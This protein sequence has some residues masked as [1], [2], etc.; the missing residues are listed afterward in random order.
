MRLYL[1]LILV[2]LN[3]FSNGQKRNNKNN[4]GKVQLTSNEVVTGHLVYSEFEKVIYLEQEDTILVFSPSQVDKFSYTEK[5]GLMEYE[6]FLFPNYINKLVPTFFQ[7]VWESDSM[8]LLT[9]W[10]TLT[11]TKT[12]TAPNGSS[13]FKFDNQGKMMPATG[14][15]TGSLFGKQK[16]TTYNYTIPNS[17][18]YWYFSDHEDRVKA[19]IKKKGG[20]RK[21]L[22]RY[23]LARLVGRQY[24]SLIQFAKDNKLS[25]DKEKDLLEILDYYAS[26]RN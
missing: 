8:K 25:F 9:R 15:S 4:S 24:K 12:Y 2:F 1:M 20:T 6:T 5:K 3:F 18:K 23:L 10:A 11:K 16:K 14:L 22:D 13:G 26:I 19:F 7:V 17:A 21:I